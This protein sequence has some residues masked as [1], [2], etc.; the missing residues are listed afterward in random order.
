LLN[1][2]ACT[3]STPFLLLT[4]PASRVGVHKK[5]GGD[6]AG[7][8]DPNKPKGYPISH[9]IPYDTVLSNGS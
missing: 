2:G 9:V 6:A 5:L 7:T 3:A 4:E 1:N 8:A